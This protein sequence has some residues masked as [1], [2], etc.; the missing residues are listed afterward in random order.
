MF[1]EL[2]NGNLPE[3]EKTELRLANEAIVMLA[4]GTETAAWS[5]CLSSQIGRKC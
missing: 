4:A 5:K 1:I 2:L 3:R